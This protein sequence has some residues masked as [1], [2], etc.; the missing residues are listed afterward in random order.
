MVVVVGGGFGM[1]VV[2]DGRWWSQLKV[3][4]DAW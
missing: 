3:E 2:V 1:V 4:V